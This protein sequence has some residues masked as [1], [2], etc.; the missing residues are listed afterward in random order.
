MIIMGQKKP[1]KARFS[2]LDQQYEEFQKFLNDMEYDMIKRRLNL[3]SLPT[4]EERHKR[5]DEISNEEMAS[6]L[7]K[8]KDQDFLF[9]DKKNTDDQKE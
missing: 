4:V 5:T 6:F 9:I 1:K 3:N 8:N 7:E 2:N